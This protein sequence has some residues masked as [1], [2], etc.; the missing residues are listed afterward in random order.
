MDNGPRLR[1]KSFREERR[2]Y[3]P[4]GKENEVIAGGSFKGSVSYEYER[5][6]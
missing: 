6:L 2:V 5:V 4:I 1:G 3:R